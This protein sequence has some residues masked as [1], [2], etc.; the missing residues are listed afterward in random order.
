MLSRDQIS[1]TLFSAIDIIL[2]ERLRNISFDQTIEC[3]ITDASK[4]INGEYTVSDAGVQY[5]AYSNLT[6]Y[7]VGD[8]VLVTIPQGDYDNQKIILGKKKNDADIPYT[9]QKASTQLIDITGN[10]IS[11]DAAKK[12]TGIQ[13]NGFIFFEEEELQPPGEEQ[14]DLTQ[15]FLKQYSAYHD[16][17]I[18]RSQKVLLWEDVFEVPYTGY[19]RLGLKGDFIS[20]LGIYNTV[21]GNYGLLLE[22]IFEPETTLGADNT[23]DIANYSNA[24]LIFASSTDF[25]GTIFNQTTFFHQEIIFDIAQYRNKKIKGARLFLFQGQDFLSDI[26]RYI[27]SANYNDEKLNELLNAEDSDLINL[28][29]FYQKFYGDETYVKRPGLDYINNIQVRNIYFSLGYDAAAF[30]GD[31]AYLFSNSKLTYNTTASDED[32]TKIVSLRWVHQF[33][34]KV[35]IVN[36]GHFKELSKEGNTVSES[37]SNATNANV[38]GYKIIWYQYSLG[39]P[40]PD[41]FCGES[42]NIITEKM[43]TGN[44]DSSIDDYQQQYLEYKFLP[45]VTLSS[46]KVKV[47][48]VRNGTILAQT[49]PFTFFNERDIGSLTQSDIENA[50][51]ITCGRKVEGSTVAD[52]E[53]D[54]ENGTFFIYGNNNKLLDSSKSSKVFYL[55]PFFNSKYFEAEME[56]A[57]ILDEGKIAI[58]SFPA[59]NSMIIPSFVPLINGVSNFTAKK[60]I[61][62]SAYSKQIED[63]EKEFGIFEDCQS[64]DYQKYTKFFTDKAKHRYLLESSGW[65]DEEERDPYFVCY[66]DEGD[67]IGTFDFV[68][69]GTQTDSERYHLITNAVQTYSIKADYDNSCFNNTI[70]LKVNRGGIDYHT[71]RTFYFGQSGSNGS[72]YTL[73]ITYKDS[74][75]R[76]LSVYDR[77]DNGQVEDLSEL[78]GYDNKALIVEAHIFDPDNK[79][80]TDEILLNVT[81]GNPPCLSW[82]WKTKAIELNNRTPNRGN[83]SADK[84]EESLILYPAFFLRRQDAGVYSTLSSHNA[85][86]ELSAGS[87]PYTSEQLAVP[88]DYFFKVN[89]TAKA[90]Y[91]SDKK[92]FISTY[93]YYDAI[94]GVFKHPTYAEIEGDPN[95]WLMRENRMTQAEYDAANQLLPFSDIQWYRYIDVTTEQKKPK[96]YFSDYSIL[97]NFTQ[98]PLYIMNGSNQIQ[99]TIATNQYITAPEELYTYLLNQGFKLFVKINNSYIIDPMSHWRDGE[100]YYYPSKIKN[101]AN[102]GRTI[103]D[104]LSIKSKEGLN[105]NQKQITITNEKSSFWRRTT[106]APVYLTSSDILNSVN[107]LQVTLENFGDYNLTDSEPIAIRCCTVDASNHLQTEDEEDG[108]IFCNY[109]AGPT[110]IEYHET[111]GPTLDE[112]PFSAFSAS[113]A[114]LSDEDLVWSLFYIGDQADDEIQRFL[115]TLKGN[116]LKPLDIFID[117]LPAIGI[118]CKYRDTILWSQP[119]DIY[120]NKYFSSK[121]NDWDGNTISTDDES[122]TIIAPAIAAGKKDPATNTFSGILLGDWSKAG[123]STSITKQT[124]LYGFHQGSM[125]F[126]FTED[127]TGFIGK[128]GRGRILFDGNNAIIQ[129]SSW[130]LQEE[131]MKLDLDDGVLEAAY[132]TTG[133]S[134]E[135]TWKSSNDVVFDNNHYFYTNYWEPEQ[136]DIT[137][138]TATNLYYPTFNNHI[139]KSQVSLGNLQNHYLLYL[140][141]DITGVFETI[142]RDQFNQAERA[143]QNVFF[144]CYQIDGIDSPAVVQKEKDKYYQYI[145]IAPQLISG[146]DNRNTTNPKIYINNDAGHAYTDFYSPSGYIALHHSDFVDERLSDK[147]D[148]EAETLREFLIAY[149]DWDDFAERDTNLIRLGCST[150]AIAQIHFLYNHFQLHP[151]D[152]PQNDNQGQ[153]NAIK[154]ALREYGVDSTIQNISDVGYVEHPYLTHSAFNLDIQNQ[155]QTYPIY[156]KFFGI[157]IDDEAISNIKW[158]R[159]KGV[160]F[161]KLSNPYILVSAE[162]HLIGTDT[163]LFDPKKR[164]YKDNVGGKKQYITL[165]AKE[166]EYPLSIGLDSTLTQRKF[167]VKWDGTLYAENGQFNGW[168]NGAY[169]SGSYLKGS[170]INAS[171][172]QANYGRIGGWVLTDRSTIQ[173]GKAPELDE[174]QNGILL[175]LHNKWEK[176]YIEIQEFEKENESEESILRRASELQDNVGEYLQEQITPLV[177][178]DPNIKIVDMFGQQIDQNAVQR[179]GTMLDPLQG[180]FTDQITIPIY[181]INNNVWNE[182]N[183][184]GTI[185]GNDSRKT[186]VNLGIQSIAPKT[187]IILSAREGNIALYPY[188]KDVNSARRGIWMG[189]LRDG[190]PDAQQGKDMIIWGERISIGGCP[191]TNFSWDNHFALSASSGAPIAF[192][193]ASLWCHVPAE[194]QYGIYAR[195]A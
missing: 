133:L 103:A 162:N 164:Y 106:S 29:Q 159:A 109:I 40:S 10:L 97:N 194:N 25:Y 150:F 23:T 68:F 117:D 54:D 82:K 168:I 122:G 152:F 163:V 142:L 193:N 149:M 99:P 62:F 9:Y 124:G 177:V 126:A 102:A 51:T 104:I 100:T 98:D 35:E 42:W 110:E 169:V 116:I 16:N 63:K 135:D 66:T 139:A 14:S 140:K 170:I 53:Y 128:A 81:N 84:L 138:S 183:Y 67:G 92:H 127:G 64:S 12:T 48:I 151:N 30:S 59:K 28:K 180:I 15:D 155:N 167:R 8:H 17:A 182:S 4:C 72:K 34:A 192:A 94:N 57:E 137:E 58:W 65:L 176:A 33:P 95:G 154:T 157:A 52:F 132:L 161:T 26:G 191:G 171:Y 32:N 78:N 188:N 44:Y 50:L 55:T 70:I 86:K 75:A 108:I 189:G 27:P 129:S 111:G 175:S 178:N 89:K 22:L 181:D 7:E 160:L 148:I 39:A 43:W 31:A 96:F 73:R 131:G 56:G 187:S 76:A 85:S 144:I 19:D 77:A 112:N 166:R 71:A 141:Q 91:E 195:F 80:I 41:S 158:S 115:P 11:S 173:K 113:G 156:R 46:E 5:Q 45:S 143:R 145:Y 2:A 13:A 83:E 61:T 47:I 146:T 87:L 49:E 186:T 6:T 105:I 79:D 184:I 179:S 37:D 69:T 172:F 3:I 38:L 147:P 153:I 118:Q 185:Y 165:S 36:G 90:E 190:V 24:Q 101:H 21:S 88:T 136:F 114:K 125:S 134:R 120:Q 119:I 174:L 107:I 93:F 130:Q 123:A 18:D 60:D 1:E 20:N 74:G 121:I